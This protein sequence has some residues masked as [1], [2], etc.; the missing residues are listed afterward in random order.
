MCV[1]RRLP[2]TSGKDMDCRVGSSQLG[3]KRSFAKRVQALGGQ[4]PGKVE[5]LLCP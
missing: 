2:G 5:S 3:A 1:L 4:I